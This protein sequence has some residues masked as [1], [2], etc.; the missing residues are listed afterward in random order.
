[1]VAEILQTGVEELEAKLPR[2]V[3]PVRAAEIAELHGMTRVGGGEKLIT[4]ERS[5]P[6]PVGVLAGRIRVWL[7]ADVVRWAQE[8]GRLG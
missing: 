7:R 1:M 6:E 4:R 2:R 3:G 8:T 5:I